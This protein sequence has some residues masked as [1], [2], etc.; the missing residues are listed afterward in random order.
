MTIWGNFEL[1]NTHAL[2]SETVPPA[3]L[4][5]M[6]RMVEYVFSEDAQCNWPYYEDVWQALI[7]IDGFNRRCWEARHRTLVKENRKVF[8]QWVSR[9]GGFD[10]HAAAFARWLEGPAA[11]PIRLSG[12]VWLYD[13][14]KVGQVNGGFH[15]GSTADAIAALLN[16]IWRQDEERLRADATV[17]AA[18]RSLLRW[19]V[20][21]QNQVALELL[22]RIG[23]L[24]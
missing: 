18:F 15:E 21:Q 4:L 23:G 24:L 3:Y 2:T 22:G 12:L 11:D 8:Q 20:N 13:V 16:V 14:F 5:T 19:L 6:R 1:T 7:G 10:R 9:M 17:S